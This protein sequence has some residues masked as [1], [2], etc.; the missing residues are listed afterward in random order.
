MSSAAELAPLW[1]LWRLATPGRAGG[2]L[3][4][5][6]AGSWRDASALLDDARGYAG[7][8]AELDSGPDALRGELVAPPSREA[9]ATALLPPLLPREIGKILALGKNFRDHAAEFG[10]AVPEE[11]LFFAKLPETVVPAGATVRVRPWYEGRVDHEA[12]LAVIVGRGGRDIPAGSALEHLAGATVANDLT[13]RSLQGR[14]RKL[15]HPWLRAKNMDGFCPLGP[16]LVPRASLE[17]GP[18][19]KGLRVSCRVR[20]ADGREELRQSASTADLVVGV[21]EA[22]SWLSRHLCLHPG[23]VILLGTP[24]GVGPLAD[25]DVVTA[26]VDAIGELATRI[27]RPRA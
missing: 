26:A 13:A 18:G 19:W 10:E 11:P 1:R 17:A 2:R 5:E 8:L 25:G 15:G 20:H 3:F 7:A 4:A 6:R 24:A 21:A 16:C 9:L 27:E 12:E 14:D 23:D 22:V